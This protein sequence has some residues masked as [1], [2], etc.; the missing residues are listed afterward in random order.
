M[1]GYHVKKGTSASIYDETVAAVA[2]IRDKYGMNPCAQIYITSPRTYGVTISDAEVAK[3]AADPSLA[4]RVYI[5]GAYVDSPW[6]GAPASI[7]NIRAEL[8]TSHNMRAMGVVIHLP[9]LL[10][11]AERVPTIVAALRRIAAPPN[12]SLGTLWL[13]LKAAKSKDGTFET[14]EKLAALFAGISAAKLS[15]RIGL[16]I[17]TQHLFACGVSFRDY[18]PTMAWLQRTR[19]LIPEEYPFLVHLN[20]SESTLGSGVDRHASLGTGRIWSDYGAAAAAAADA[21]TSGIMAVAVWA[22]RNSVACI[23]ETSAP[24][25]VCLPLLHNMGVFR[26]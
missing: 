13:E 17:D 10:S 22:E 24:T 8:A 14:P 1:I 16:C 5:H 3:F 21:S 6:K 25:E 7:G 26:V 20:D 2:D 12:A 23:L 11:E 9:S 4:G 18:E 15:L 19:E